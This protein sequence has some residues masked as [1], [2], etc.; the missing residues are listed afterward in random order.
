MPAHSSSDSGHDEISLDQATFARPIPLDEVK[1]CY[2]D[3]EPV[4]IVCNYLLTSLGPGDKV[5]TKC[6]IGVLSNHD[7]DVEECETINTYLEGVQHPHDT[8]L[9]Q[10]SQELCRLNQDALS[11]ASAPG[12]QRSQRTRWTSVIPSD[13]FQLAASRIAEGWKSVE[14]R[15]KHNNKAAT[16]AVKPPPG[17]EE[18]EYHLNPQSSL[19]ERMNA[20]CGPENYTI[21]EA[22]FI[23]MIDPDGVKRSTPYIRRLDNTVRSHAGADFPELIAGY[24]HFSKEAFIKATRERIRRFDRNRLAGQRWA[25]VSPK[26]FDEMMESPG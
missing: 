21:V 17:Q 7:P 3:S 15:H 22:L 1:Q 24:E 25:I 16:S 18:T 23:E 26:D 12:D 19:A 13:F 20:F 6:H 4:N 2:R 5:Q 9:E 10:Q 8:F 11:S 14:E